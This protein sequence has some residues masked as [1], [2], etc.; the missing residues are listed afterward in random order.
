MFSLP[1]ENV[2]SYISRVFPSWTSRPIDIPA[3]QTHDI[4]VTADRRS[5]TL[6]HLIKANHANFSIIYHDLKYHTHM[7]HILGSA[8]L[9]DATSEHLN[10]VYEHEGKMLEPWQDAPGEISEADWR[11]F[12]GK[13]EYQRAFVDFFEDQLVQHGYDWK[14]LLRTYL[15]DGDEPLINNMISGLGHPL[16]HLAYAYE[17]NSHTIAVEALTGTCCYYNF[18]HK[19]IDNPIYTQPPPEHLASTSPFILLQ[20]ISQD[21]R[22]DIF[23]HSGDANFDAVFEKREDAVME[24]WNAWPLIEPTKQFEQSQILAVGLLVA[25][26]GSDN[27]YDF[28]MVH[29][30]TTSHALRVLLPV[31]PAGFQL[32]IVL[33][34]WLL[35]IAVYIAQLRPEINLDVIEKVDREGKDWKYIDRMAVT[36]PHSFDT[37]YVKALRAMK[38]AASAWG[39]EDEF[40]IKAAIKFA[41]GFSGWGGFGL[42]AEAEVRENSRPKKATVQT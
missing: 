12:L 34:W 38:E 30:L 33:Q 19:Y 25:T 8:F 16:I 9:L 23:S 36:G 15:F 40:F 21:Y 6:K 4:E 14:A 42:D 28:F 39:D 37:H 2:F 17:L 27:K 3:V 13:R 32:T 22:F 35:T 29:L 10:E 41:D 18:L 20:K 24:Y 31:L 7:P 26:H 11:D 1:R 5:R